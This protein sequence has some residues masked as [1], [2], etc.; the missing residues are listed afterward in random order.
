MEVGEVIEVYRSTVRSKVIWIFGLVNDL[1]FQ[2]VNKA[3]A[4]AT[5][6][7]AS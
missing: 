3:S 4:Q 5:R 2:S 1:R 6:P 7:V